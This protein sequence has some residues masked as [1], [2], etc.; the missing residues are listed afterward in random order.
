MW[1][2]GKKGK[3]YLHGILNTLQ[4]HIGV[5]DIHYVTRNPAETLI[6]STVYLAV[7]DGEF[8]WVLPV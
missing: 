2:E 5:V 6:D 3:R 4:R 8:F 1:S 7:F